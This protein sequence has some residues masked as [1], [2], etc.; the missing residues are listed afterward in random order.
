MTP[1]E[2]LY[3][4]VIMQHYKRPQNQGTLPPPVHPT[5]GSDPACGDQLELYLH[6]EGGR[7]AEV[8]W[9]G[10]GCAISTAS[11]SMMTQL[12]QGKTWDEVFPLISAFKSMIVE[13]TPA[14]PQLGDLQALSGVHRLPAR[15][16][17][18]TLAWNTLE[19]AARELGVQTV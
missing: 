17:C 9:Q 11:A 7:I 6:L 12:I 18:A 3:R 15:V 1:L 16:K 14:G 8:R 4:A 5:P 13:G 2:D 19:E 10:Q